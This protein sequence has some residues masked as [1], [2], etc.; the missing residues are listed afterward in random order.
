MSTSIIASATGSEFKNGFKVFN[1]DQSLLNTLLKQYS[2]SF[3]V[4]KQSWEFLG[5]DEYLLDDGCYR[6]RRYSVFKLDHGQLN[7]L[8]TEPHFQ[9]LEHNPL[10]GNIDRHYQDWSA[11]AYKNECF[12]VILDWVSEQLEFSLTGWR[13]QGHQFRI[14]ASANAIGKPSPEGIHK[15]GADFVLIMLMDRSNVS[16]G[17]STLYNNQRELIQS[18]TLSN[19]GDCILLDDTAVYHNSSLISPANPEYDAYRDTLVLTFHKPV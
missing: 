14:T 8:E 13:I 12:K 3:E 10:H 5:P 4:L 17:V 7:K 18:L 11:F 6:H 15:D 9:K 2:P 1:G 16:G 19:P